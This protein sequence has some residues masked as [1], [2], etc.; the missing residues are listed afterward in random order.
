MSFGEALPEIASPSSE[1]EGPTDTALPASFFC[2]STA[3]N[4]PTPPMLTSVAAHDADS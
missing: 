1:I 2:R 3:L 4:S